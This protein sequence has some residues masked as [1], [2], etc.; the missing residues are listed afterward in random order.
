MMAMEKLRTWETTV[1]GLRIVNQ[2][3]SHTE[4]YDGDGEIENLGDDS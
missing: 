3:E 4:L 2:Q 1:D